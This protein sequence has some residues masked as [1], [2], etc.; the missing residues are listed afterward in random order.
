[1]IRITTFSAT[2]QTIKLATL[3]ESRYTV[4]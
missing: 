1:M 3:D 4:L 2:N